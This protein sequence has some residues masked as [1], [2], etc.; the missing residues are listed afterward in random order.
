MSPA[1]RVAG[2][3]YGARFGADSGFVGAGTPFDEGLVRFAAGFPADGVSAA[4]NRDGDD[5]ESADA[6]STNVFKA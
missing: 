3:F 2:F 5:N 4:S 6:P 1:I